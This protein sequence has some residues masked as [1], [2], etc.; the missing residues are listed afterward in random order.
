MNTPAV[1]SR[2]GIPTGIRLEM[3]HLSD[4]LYPA[5]ELMTALHLQSNASVDIR[6]KMPEGWDG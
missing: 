6:A 1:E 4:M 2:S 5:R 3:L